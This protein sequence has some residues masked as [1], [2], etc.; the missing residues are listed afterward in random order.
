MPD[1]C[2]ER[3]LEHPTFPRTRARPRCP[4]SAGLSTAPQTPPRDAHTAQNNNG[5]PVPEP[6]HALATSPGAA[7]GPGAARPRGSLSPLPVH[8][9]DPHP[10]GCC[11]TPP[12]PPAA[13]TDTALPQHRRHSAWSSLR[14]SRLRERERERSLPTATGRG[15]KTHPHPQSPLRAVPAVRNEL[16]Q[17]QRAPP[18][19]SSCSHNIPPGAGRGS[20]EPGGCRTHPGQRRAAPGEGSTALS[21]PR[22]PLPGSPRRSIPAQRD[23]ALHN[24]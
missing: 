6:P 13:G 2:V 24:R 14:K 8:R 22:Q 18:P 12:A 15:A 16:L 20:P 7:E 21:R 5:D 10:R 3:A 9:G 19:P 1:L 23:A 17:P 11:R 4:T